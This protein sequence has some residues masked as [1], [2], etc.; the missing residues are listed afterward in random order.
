MATSSDNFGKSLDG[1][2]KGRSARWSFGRVQLLS[3]RLVHL[4]LGELEQ[5]QFYEVGHVYVRFLY[6]LSLCLVKLLLGDARLL[7]SWAFV[8]LFWSFALF[9]IRVDP[10]REPHTRPSPSTNRSLFVICPDWML[11]LNLST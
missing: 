3:W 9:R 4:L 5:A 7:S 10:L 11:F 6:T 1:S 8:R 2:S